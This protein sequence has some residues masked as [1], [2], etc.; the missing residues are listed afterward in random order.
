M[1][2]T[3]GAR[4]GSYELIGALG[5]GGMGEVYRAR[6]TRLDR[7]VALKILPESFAV[8]PD[9]RARFER[10]AK[11][12]AALNHP[13]IA[14]VFGFEIAGDVHAIAMELV[15]GRTLAD[16]IAAGPMSVADALAIARQLATAL[17]AAH[18]QGIVH[19]DLKPANVIVR[20]DG[21]VKVLDFG[22]AKAFA[23]DA[24]TSGSN[25][26]NSP[27][28]TARATQLGM[29]IGTAAYMAPEQAKGRSVD[30]R[31]DIWAFGVVLYE[32]L[33][34]RRA[35]EGDDI[36][37]VLASVLKT[38][39]DWTALP[40]DLPAPLRRLLRRCLEKDPK[41]RL[42]DLSEGM[43][44]LEEELA[45]PVDRASPASTMAM[46]IPGD[47]VAAQPRSWWRRVL[48]GAALVLAAM[49]IAA[50]GWFRPAAEIPGDRVAFTYLPDPELSYFNTQGNADLAIAN[51]GR[52]FVYGSGNST[53]P[54]LVL[55]RF[56]ALDGVV[57]R[58]GEG[59]NPFISADEEWVGYVDFSDRTIIRKIPVSGGPSTIVAKARTGVSG[60]TWL[61]DDSIVFG[62]V[63]GLWRVP[64]GG[65]E[66]VQLT[67]L[68]T[69]RSESG[70]VGPSDVPGTD[71]VL[72]TTATGAP[73][74]TGRLAAVN[75]ITREVVRFDVGGVSPRYLP[76]GHIAFGT[77]DGSIRVVGFDAR[78]IQTVGNPV[79][80]IEGVVVKPSGA[81]GFDISNEG[82]I[83]YVTGGGQIPNRSIAWVDRS[84]RETVLPVP[85]RA[86]FY[87]RSSPTDLSRLSLDVR[88]EGSD[89]WIWDARG[90]L[91]KLTAN[92][93]IDQYGLWT[94]DGT[95]VVFTSVIEGKSGL[96]RARADGIG[97]PELL[98]EHAGAFPNAVTPD[99]AAVVF[100]VGGGGN[101][102]FVVALE[103]ER[104]ATPLIATQHDELNAALSPD[105]KWIA[106]QSDLSGRPEI[107]VRPFPD[108]NG[109]QWTVST[110]G[111]SEPAWSAN[112]QEIYYLSADNKMMAV[113][114]TTRPAVALTPPQQLFDASGY[115]SGGIGR[116]YDVA[117]DGRFVLVKEAPNEAVATR[118]ITVVLNWSAQFKAV[119][120][121]R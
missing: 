66:P 112:G 93:G 83:V 2:L 44:Q 43:L 57:L 69:S 120:P 118:P 73:M 37:D 100:R 96:Y 10:E 86:Y 53:R 47:G 39:P 7:D 103:G 21:T 89:I 42:R 108:V 95:Q 90:T 70:H 88:D 51:S 98:V 1:P 6:D 45:A 5:A 49:A 17:D 12:L 105:G 71:L 119:A 114:F 85:L 27:T 104:K 40:A 18:E 56:D 19:R 117:R 84:G 34:G 113:G 48:P 121:D 35:F 16:T 8:D 64:P 26:A 58:G 79:P 33:T 30:R 116:N 23:T 72:F 87:V 77:A 3:P 82:R 24:D 101:D 109:G 25:V 76:T 63:S 80:A 68:D 75:V 65:G 91:T 13:N 67:P 41:K 55:K 102:I 59:V 15:E 74:Q 110:A 92:D 29:I 99:G 81:A 106:Y 36:S 62:S 54:R 31:A 111:G 107:Y 78:R 52:F 11:A 38:D 20:D 28:L 94:P 50:A 9:R 61:A 32:M 60:A 4:I 22:L 97:R 14:Q 46:P 115:F